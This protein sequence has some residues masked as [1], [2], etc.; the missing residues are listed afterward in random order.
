NEPHVMK[1]HLPWLQHDV[2]RSRFVNCHGD[3]LAAAQQIVRRESIP[4]RKLLERMRSGHDTHATVFSCT[5]RERDPRGHNVRLRKAPVRR[6]LVPRNA[7]RIMGILYEEPR[8][9]AQNIWP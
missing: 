8:A 6:I 2:H 5:G 7:P 1:G 3:L 4:M 9:P